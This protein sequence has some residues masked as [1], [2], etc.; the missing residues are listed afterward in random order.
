MQTK[1]YLILLLLIIMVPT[2]ILG[3]QSFQ[4]EPRPF[5][6]DS[7]WSIV[8]F[9][10]VLQTAY[11]F[12]NYF[13]VLPP[14]PGREWMD[15]EHPRKVVD[16]KGH[17]HV[18]WMARSYFSTSSWEIWYQVLNAQT[19]VALTTP[20]MISKNDR[21]NSVYPAIAVDYV[22]RG[23][24]IYSH[25]VWIDQREQY[26]EIYY[27]KIAFTGTAAIDLNP[28]DWRV[29][30][31][32]FHS[33]R[34]VFP[35][36][37]DAMNTS[38]IEH[39]DI[40]ID[41]NGNVHIVWS[42]ARDALSSSISDKWEVYY[43]MQDRGTNWIPATPNTII[44]DTRISNPGRYDASSQCPVIAVDRWSI[45]TPI[46]TKPAVYI[47]WQDASDAKRNGSNWEIWFEWCIPHPEDH[48]LE[49]IVDDMMVTSA[50]SP[51]A[52]PYPYHDI[53]DDGFNSAKPDLDS[54]ESQVN[55]VSVHL[56]WMDDRPVPPRPNISVPFLRGQWEVYS[57]RL[58]CDRTARTVRK[59]FEK[60]Q[61]DMYSSG[62]YGDYKYPGKD[63]ASM[64]PRIIVNGDAKTAS[65]PQGQVRIVWHDNRNKNW[66]IYYTEIMSWCHNPNNDQRVTWLLKNDMYADI[67]LMPDIY[68]FFPHLPDIKWQSDATGNWEIRNAVRNSFNWVRVNID[69]Y[70]YDMWPD[71][72]FSPDT[73]GLN[74][75]YNLS[76]PFDPAFEWYHFG[77]ADTI[78][79]ANT[80]SFNFHIRFDTLMIADSYYGMPV[81]VNLHN[82]NQISGIE[83]TIKDTPNLLTYTNVETTS[84]T[85]N[86]ETQLIDNGDETLILLY[87]PKGARIAVGNGPILQLTVAPPQIWPISLKYIDMEISESILMSRSN[88]ALLHHRIDG[89]Y[90]MS[91]KGDINRDGNYNIIDVVL[92]IDFILGRMTPNDYQKWAADINDDGKINIIDLNLLINF[93]IYPVQP[94]PLTEDLPQHYAYLEVPG[95]TLSQELPK[96][97]PVNLNAN[98]EISAVQLV[99]KYNAEAIKFITPNLASDVNEM[100]FAFENRPGEF[101]MLVYSLKEKYI[102]AGNNALLNLS[103]ETLDESKPIELTIED[104]IILDKNGQNTEI[105]TAI[106]S[107]ELANATPHNYELS[108]TYPNPFNST[109]T[110]KYQLPKSSLVTIKVYS[111]L[112]QEIRTLVNEQKTAGY[113]S[114]K[115]DGKD[116]RNE[117]VATGVYLLQ[118]KSGEFSKIRKMLMIR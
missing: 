20:L 33:G 45:L 85:Q 83:I 95:L 93:I 37:D 25:V 29:S 34:A 52:A 55:L 19:G 87:S 112:G 44:N 115:W 84:R 53:I 23:D 46:W 101:K 78:H 51:I 21:R 92:M 14:L 13:R 107:L 10:A 105:T 27:S 63:G 57:M 15:D 9:E 58:E 81:S 75:V 66:E 7:V 12:P 35:E 47:A 103:F 116:N 30:D 89:K 11:I 5:I 86:F 110:I 36:T 69:G 3:Q 70:Y 59:M 28:N 90:F 2:T 40:D 80:D 18:V 117:D 98:S 42:D 113:Y 72:Q 106:G 26:N 32:R 114:I 67:G 73:A 31:A 100:E 38:F 41:R 50:V 56:V 64:Y 109:T 97:I 74:V 82:V 4:I 96:V 91:R 71:Y 43:Q 76:M 17:A 61:S 79:R 65:R 49:T 1:L 108:P 24:T 22:M 48:Y 60:R 54:D 77:A 104:V 102:S 68:P 62:W 39:P 118:I 6:Y 16:H 94:V 111:L 8:D 99:L 88:Q